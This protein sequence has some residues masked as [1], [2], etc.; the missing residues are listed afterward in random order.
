MD[1]GGDIV[2]HFFGRDIV[3]CGGWMKGVK[4]LGPENSFKSL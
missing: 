3:K 2:T 4:K 1:R